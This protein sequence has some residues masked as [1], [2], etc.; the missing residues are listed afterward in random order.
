MQNSSDYAVKVYTIGSGEPLVQIQPG[1]SA[2][3]GVTS[4]WS[5]GTDGGVMCALAPNHNQILLGA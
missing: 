5:S 4:G 1:G 3:A 2:Q